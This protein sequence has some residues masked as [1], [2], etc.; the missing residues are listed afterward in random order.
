MRVK[1]EGAREHNLKGVDAEIG[2]GL[3]VVTGVSGS[4]KTSLVF[5]TVYHEARR[6]FQEA[7]T[8]GNPRQSQ[9]P[10]DVD[11]VTG[12][13][14]AVAVGQNLLNRNPNSTLATASGLHPFLRLLYA[15]YGTRVCR[16]CGEQLF[17]LTEDEIVA[18]VTSLLPEEPRILAPI[19]R[20]STGSHRTLLRLLAGEFEPE[21]IHVDG[22]PWSGDS[23]DPEGSHSVSV[24]IASLEADADA[25]E[26]RRAVGTVWAL[27]A[28]TVQVQGRETRYLSRSRV[29]SRCGESY[30]LIQPTMFHVKCPHCEGEGCTEC[31]GTGLHP[32][33]A[34]VTIAGHTL[35]SL[36]ALT[37]DQAAALFNSTQLKAVAPR[38]HSEV[39]RRLD[40]LCRVGLGYIQLDRSSPSLS[41]GESQR[42]RLAVSLTS[43]LEDVLHVLDEPT[44]GQHP[45]DVQRLLPAFRELGGPVLY[46]EHDSAAAAYADHAIDLGPGAGSDGGTVVYAGPPSGLWA[47]DTHTGMYFSGRRRVEPPVRRPALRRF[48]E[49]RGAS[50]HN[51]KDVDASFPRG[52]LTVVTGVSGSGKTTLVEDVLYGSLRGGEPVGCKAV[53]GSVKPVLVDQSPIGRNPRS[54][55]ATYT[56]LSDILRDV[57]HRETGGS[58]SMFSFN[59][60]EG[61]CPSCGGMGA[62]E[63]KMRYMPST[64]IT[65]SDC[66]GRR[67]SDEALRHTISHRGERL[68][69]AD[70]YEK[71]VA[72]AY[73]LLGELPIDE[74]PRRKAMRVLEALIDLGLGYLPLGQPSPSLSGGEAQR[75]KLAK[76]LGA[77]R[78]TDRAVILDEPSTGLHP[79]DLH[80]LLTVLHRLTMD[81]ATVIVVEHNTDIIRAADWVIDLGPGAG[82][83]GGRVVYAGP[84]EGLEDSGGATG[85]AMA[86]HAAVKPR[87]E[88]SPWR[89]SHDAIM[90]RG[91][92]ANNLRGVDVDIPKGKLTVVTGVS[93]SGKSSLVT[94]TLER[95][96]R[97]RYLETLSL[98]ERQSVREGPEAPVDSVKGLGV[99]LTITPDR[100]LYDRRGTVGVAT[101]ISHHLAAVYSASADRM[102]PSCG[103]AMT[104]GAHWTC[105]QCG[106]VSEN[107]SPGR[108]SP[109]SYGAAC[110]TCH[111]VGSLQ[112][113]APE[114]LI[115]DP[116]KPLCGGAMHSPGFFPQGYLCQPGNG[117]YDVV[118]AFAQRHGFSPSETPWNRIPVEVREMFLH[119]DPEPLTVTFRNRTGRTY[120]RSV[121]F[122]GFY[123][124]I[125]DWDVGGTYTDNVPCPACGG[126]KLRPE[127][128]AYTVQG[129][130]IHQLSTMSLRD[131]TETLRGYTLPKS[132][133]AYSSLSTIKHRLRFLNQVGLGYLN[134][135]RVAA[136]LSAGE[137]QRVKLAGLLGSGL[138][139]L[140]VLLDEPTRGLHP[141]EVTSLNA[142]LKELRD[143]GN[144][145]VVVEHDLQ[146]IREADYLLDMGPG[147]G[148]LGGTVTAQ[149]TPE[150][151]A[152]KG[153]VTGQWLKGKRL[154]MKQSPRKPGGWMTVKGASENNLKVDTLRVPLGVLVGVCGVSGSGKSTLLID[155]IAR[156]LVPVKQTTSVAR[157]PV[158]PGK[159]EAIHDAPER[160]FTVDQ[161]RKGI[162]SPMKYLGLD[163]KLARLYSESPEAAQ[164]G[165]T[166]KDLRRSCTVCGGRGVTRT[167]MGFLP[168]IVTQC[169]TCKG[170]GLAPE[171]WQVKLHGLSLPQAT[172]LTLRQLHEAFK[173][174]RITKTVKPALD[175]GL[176]Y[177]VLNQPGAALSG[178]EAQRLKIAG[179]LRKPRKGSLVILDEPTL[180]QHMEDVERLVGVLDRLVDSGC[181]V[182]V[183]EHHPDVLAQCDHLIELGP[184]GG[185]YGGHVIAEGSP[186]Q[187][188]R[189]DTPTGHVLKEMEEQH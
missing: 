104:R 24:H 72:E 22:A 33:A 155:T 37:V 186:V 187:V 141:T 35:P 181:T 85:R 185:A 76:Y 67:Y 9:P 172:A 177:L 19:V 3:T 153:T 135:D 20:D 17:T 52:R 103:H 136:T 109:T 164:M 63:V 25:A 134:L 64:W 12:L 95:E 100:K 15:R 59:R 149:G 171:T 107:A 40:A 147:A 116:G 99:T 158:E 43:S 81:G 75:I 88:A 130:N 2:D 54:T 121:N 53:E 120:T 105:P 179:I 14:P 188:A 45:A 117:G 27:G 48:I 131:L 70:L 161:S 98:Y 178:G 115:V 163:K 159:H 42:V 11:R 183:V 173:D 44:I 113:P 139:S 10:A 137:A 168:D 78:L 142:A 119:G 175:V 62:V 18:E 65:C 145:V 79:W 89:Q 49:V 36:L 167:D 189:R 166:E 106:H 80:G 165:L 30:G 157:E 51:L 39:Q 47:A 50:M 184:G 87:G 123:G 94:D 55:P 41:R 74:A 114:K 169:E 34:A 96:A 23:L 176:G 29:C 83:D 57:F 160:T 152:E 91:A 93:G 13:G 8:F 148:S 71:P 26:V 102:C 38:L 143:N 174:A 97:R 56:K 68:S 84:P 73:R 129:M 69:I 32:E 126:A 90:V 156:A 180:G 7:F 144:T 146:V 151:V 162:R 101:E 82:P 128:L 125:R 182:I 154:G 140:T 31:G 108:F 21:A 66:G 111:G 132:S 110:T 133:P 61:A 124:W 46:V 92:R 118:Q 122:E 5:D 28:N 16:R 77:A 60:P 127:Y 58:P 86:E 1:V 138:T 170:T 6:R 4:G 112:K 150:E